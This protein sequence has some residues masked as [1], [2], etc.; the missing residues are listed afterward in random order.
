MNEMKGL[1]DRPFVYSC[2]LSH[3]QTKHRAVKRW[4]EEL[5]VGKNLGCHAKVGFSLQTHL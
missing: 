4:G 1:V 5:D 2:F 3:Q